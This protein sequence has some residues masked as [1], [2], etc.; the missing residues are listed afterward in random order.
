MISFVKFFERDTSNKGILA[1]GDI[2]IVISEHVESIIL[3]TYCGSEEKKQ[4]LTTT[5]SGLRTILERKMSEKTPFFDPCFWGDLQMTQ[6]KL[7]EDIIKVEKL[8]AQKE[9]EIILWDD[10]NFI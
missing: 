9:G 7:S 2:I 4:G 5:Y 1:S 10:K 8:M 3:M 6:G